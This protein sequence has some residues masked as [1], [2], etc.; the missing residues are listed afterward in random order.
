M[1]ALDSESHKQL[2]AFIE[3][4]VGK[5]Y[6]WTH[7]VGTAANDYMKAYSTWAYTKQ[8]MDHWAQV[9]REQLD[10]AHGK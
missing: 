4:E 2:A 10:A 1:E 3:T 7:G 9:I 6:N 8:A 5:K